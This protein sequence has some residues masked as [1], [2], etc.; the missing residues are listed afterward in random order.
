[1]LQK[2]LGNGTREG[3]MDR[4][5]HTDCPLGGASAMEWFALVV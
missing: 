4:Y 1:M 3:E 5:Q 2:L